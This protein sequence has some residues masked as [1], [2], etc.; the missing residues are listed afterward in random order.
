M[1]IPMSAYEGN[2]NDFVINSYFE[3]LAITQPEPVKPSAVITQTKK[4][5]FRTRP[6][7]NR[8]L[9]IRIPGVPIQER[10]KV[11]NDVKIGDLAVKQYEKQFTQDE[12]AIHEQVRE[13][14]DGEYYIRFIKVPG[15]HEC[16]FETSSEI[17]AAWIRDGISKRN[18]RGYESFLHVFEDVGDL[19]VRSKYTEDLFPGTADGLRAMAAHDAIH[20]RMVAQAKQDA[21]AEDAKKAKT[22]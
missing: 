7:T 16:Y 13:A 15:R 9:S 22:A 3:Q 1:S 4:Y 8:S 18:Q 5:L 11:K 2:P 19:F 14:L 6:G 20:E 21:A 10:L 17:V 12:R